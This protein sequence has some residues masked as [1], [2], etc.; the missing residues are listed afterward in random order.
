[1]GSTAHRCG[2]EQYRGYAICKRSQMHVIDD[3]EYCQNHGGLGYRVQDFLQ[4]DQFAVYSNRNNGQC[5]WTTYIA[6]VVEY[7]MPAYSLF[8]VARGQ[9]QSL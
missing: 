6:P 9:R 7:R 1:M 4:T 8:W 2:T 5:S 3:V